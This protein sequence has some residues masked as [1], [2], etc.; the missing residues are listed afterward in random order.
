M[1]EKSILFGEK[2]VYQELC[3]SRVSDCISRGRKCES[4]LGHIIFIEIDHEIIFR[5]ILIQE[6]QLSVT[7]K[8]YGHMYWLNA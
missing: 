3:F 8:K 7:D 1:R 5:I 6:G 2:S 4:Q